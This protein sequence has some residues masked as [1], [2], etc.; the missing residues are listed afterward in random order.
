MNWKRNLLTDSGGFQMVSLSKLSKVTEEGV[1]FQSPHDGTMMTLTPEHSMHIQNQI[2][3]DIMMAL[4]DVVSSTTTGPRV[5]V[6]LYNYSFFFVGSI[7]P[8][9]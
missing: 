2:G 1:Y 8:C 3:A 7:D 6:R 5:E 9:I 4:D